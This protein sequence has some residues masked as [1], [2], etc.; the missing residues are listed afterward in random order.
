M[1]GPGADSN[2]PSQCVFDPSSLMVEDIVV[3][4]L[5]CNDI[6][7]FIDMFDNPS[8]KTKLYGARSLLMLLKSATQETQS[9]IQSKISLTSFLETILSIIK[10]NTEDLDVDDEMDELVE[11]CLGI[12]SI[13]LCSFSNL[14]HISQQLVQTLIQIVLNEADATIALSNKRDILTLISN[15]VNKDVQYRDV[16]IEHG[17]SYISTSVFSDYIECEQ[18]DDIVPFISLYPNICKVHPPPPSEVVE[19]II[20]CV[21]SHV[22]DCLISEGEEA[23]ESLKVVG[24]EVLKF[25][26]LIAHQEIVQCDSGLL[27]NV[28]KLSCTLV[29]FRPLCC[30]FLEA[31]SNRHISFI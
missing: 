6:P 30:E 7:L 10:A 26:A 1:E 18:W 2:S 13:L 15:L 21:V 25:L 28:R 27:E 14:E 8:T 3:D 4:H 31:Q 12:L 9:K 11:N 23:E 17:I 22:L 29:E 19:E 5:S 24:L 20:E 16:A